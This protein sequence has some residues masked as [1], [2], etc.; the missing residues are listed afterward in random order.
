MK[1]LVLQSFPEPLLSMGIKRGMV[2]DDSEWQSLPIDFANTKFF[3]PQHEPKFEIGQPVGVDNYPY[4]FTISEVI[5]IEKGYAYNITDPNSGKVYTVPEFLLYP[6]ESTPIFEIGGL[7]LYDNTVVVIT[8]LHS[9]RSGH[10]YDFV[11]RSHGGSEWY[12]MPEKLLKPVPIQTFVSGEYVVKSGQLGIVKSAV[13][14]GGGYRYTVRFENG[15]QF[16]DMTESELKT[17][18]IYYFINSEGVVCRDFEERSNLT[19]QALEWRRITGNYF[20]SSDIANECKQSI[21]SE[22]SND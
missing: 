10:S 3:E 1:Y 16:T 9:S 17:A 21:L 22:W 6:V 12:D 5:P 4:A 7:A 20:A 11:S 15:K 14:R 2:I 18:T 8:N 13:L 19:R